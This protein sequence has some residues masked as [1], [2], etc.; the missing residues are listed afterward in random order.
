MMFVPEAIVTPALQDP[1]TLL[2]YRSEFAPPRVAYT[3][4]GTSVASSVRAT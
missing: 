1:A 2:V 3:T 4:C